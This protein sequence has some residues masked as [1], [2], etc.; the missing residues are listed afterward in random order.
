MHSNHEKITIALWSLLAAAGMTAGKLVVGLLTNS[1]GIIAEALHSGLDLIATAMTL[2]AVRVSGKPPDRNHTYGHGK[3]ENLSALGQTLLLLI[4]AGWVIYEAA[5][6]LFFR[7][8]VEIDPSVWAFLLVLACIGV[9]IWRAGALKRAADK[10]HSQALEADALHFSTDIWS[11]L[12]VLAGLTGVW[13][14]Q[15]WGLEW[16]EK[17]DAVAAFAVSV[18]VIY[19]SIR[20]GIRSVAVLSDQTSEELVERIAAAGRVAGV[21]DVKDVRVR[22]SGAGVFADLTAVI[23][24]DLNMEAAHELAGKVIAAV[25]QVVPDA[26]VVVHPE[27]TA[28]AEED[29][30]TTI[31]VLAKRHGLEAHDVHAIHEK[32]GR[33]TV[34]LHVELDP[35]LNLKQAHERA[36]RFEEEMKGQ[37]S[38]ID[39]VITHLEPSFAGQ[40]AETVPGDRPAVEKVIADF[41]ASSGAAGHAHAFRFQRTGLGLAL[42]FHVHLDGEL[43]I[44]EAHEITRE[45]ER[46]LRAEF[47]ALH[48]VTIHVEPHPE[49]DA[50]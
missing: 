23:P 7:E 48:R 29:R 20:L 18:L 3:F 5:A 21:L 24:R 17:L 16:L 10:Y 37:F 27:P 14:G 50:E 26:D 42:S 47:P 11:S 8:G 44:H 41:F 43:P 34:E 40:P 25:R 45:L 2:W 12:V 35:T 13:V 38:D 22:Q 46:R 4:T 33:Q 6:R 28:R 9:D 39:E 49:S 1:L 19:V 15:R 31:R 30:A 36:S 32:N